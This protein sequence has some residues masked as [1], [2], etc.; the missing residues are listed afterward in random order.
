MLHH[1]YVFTAFLIFVLYFIVQS[2]YTFW[3][4]GHSWRH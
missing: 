2:I 1:D 3:T 4:G